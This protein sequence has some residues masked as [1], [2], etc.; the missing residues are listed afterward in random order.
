MLIILNLFLER[1]LIGI[2]IN[3]YGICAGLTVGEFPF[4][5]L[6]AFAY[7]YIRI[8]YYI[9]IRFCGIYERA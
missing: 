5:V 3:G 4:I 6:A 2:E 1:N 9:S 8:V 7:I